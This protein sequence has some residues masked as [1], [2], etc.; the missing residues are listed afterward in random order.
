MHHSRS[1]LGS[2]VRPMLIGLQ[3]FALAGCESSQQL[4][5]EKPQFSA[6]SLSPSAWTGQY[7]VHFITI[8]TADSSL[9]TGQQTQAYGTPRTVDGDPV[10]EAPITWSIAPENVATISSDGVITGGSTSG[11]ATVYATA[12]NVTRSMTITV[13]ATTVEA[14]PSGKP[15]H[16]VTIT[17]SA[18]TIKVGEEAQVSGVVRDRNGTPIDGVP[19]TWTTS[20][21]SVATAVTVNSTSGVITGRGAGTATVYANADTIQRQI[22]ITVTG[23]AASQPS[24]PPPGANGGSFGV[25]NAAE[26]PR[27]SVNTSYPSTSRQ[28]RVPS[29]G[30]LQ[31]A[32]NSAQPG[33][34][35]L[36]AAGGRYLGAYTLPNKGSSS[37]WIVIRTDVSDAALGS[38]G[39]RMTPS[40]AASANLA[41]LLTTDVQPPIQ[42]EWGAHNYR[43]VGVELG[44]ANGSGVV[45][46]LLRFGSDERE[47]NSGNTANNLVV[48]RVYAHGGPSL[49]LTRC[50]ALNSAS[51]AIID[52]WF[53][54]CHSNQGESQAIAGWNG[55]GPFLIQNNHLE[56]GHEVVTF[57]GGTYTVQGGA[58]SDITLRGNHIMRP[59]SW[60]GVWQSKNLF[61][62]KNVRRVLLEGNVFE[63]NWEDAQNGFAILIKSVNQYN[64]NPWTQSADVTIRYNRIRNTGN[65]FNLSGTGGDGLPDVKAARVSLY[66]NLIEN[67]N[68]G[69]FNADGIIFQLING[70][71]DVAIFHNT[72]LNSGLSLNALL[73]DGDQLPRLSFHSNVEYSG[74]YGVFASGGAGTRALQTYAPGYLF[75]NNVLIG[76]ECG[77]LP[78]TTF[79]PSSMPSSLG[80]GYDGRTVGADLGQ[81]DA[82]TRNAIVNP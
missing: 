20:P 41:K 82:Q 56:A 42:T 61:E 62:T 50:V 53:G 25:S 16:M 28:I 80:Q 52:S 24:A 26:L 38:P 27:A 67:V 13:E 70:I 59:T 60:R 17:A 74:Q 75:A 33:D 71:S 2:I 40:R 43:I 78:A 11:T 14:K 7:N 63:N 1:S 30:N 68:T 58:P 46:T 45:S 35:I 81:V 21:A 36:L 15:T 10:N 49:Q 22:T 77:I 12:D 51:T 18:T 8:T 66:D 19:I 6:D 4:L 31:E 9:T 29:G 69:I 37:G 44:S 47:Q 79:C 34:E 65:V 23:E 32:I 64:D 57:G 3:L 73:F 55:P 72:V 54:E 48:D 76:G 5:V 39:T